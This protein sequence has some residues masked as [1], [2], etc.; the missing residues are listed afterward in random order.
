M[1]TAASGSTAR[2]LLGV[3]A[4]G[5]LATIATMVAVVG[6]A[7]LAKAVGVDFEIP[8]DG[9]VIPLGGFATV[10]GFFCLLGVVLAVALSRWS[11]HPSRWFIRTTVVLT[12]ASL[13]PP[14]LAGADAGTT[15]TLVALHLIAAAVVIPVL[16]VRLRVA[17]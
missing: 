17:D 2:R 6:A 10:T 3:A 11:P 15:A 4:A 16:A 12:A 13:V 8:D 14:F 7:A 9:E 5:L 1:S